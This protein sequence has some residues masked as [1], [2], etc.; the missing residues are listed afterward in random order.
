MIWEIQMTVQ[1]ER[2]SNLVCKAGAMH[3]CGWWYIIRAEPHEAAFSML[4]VPTWAIPITLSLL[5]PLLQFHF[6]SLLF[7][8]HPIAEMNARAVLGLQNGHA[9]GGADSNRTSV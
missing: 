1:R 2:N 8:A 4:E 6:P 5:I 9:I 3:L 7:F